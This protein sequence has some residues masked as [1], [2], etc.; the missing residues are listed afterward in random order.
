[1]LGSA[2]LVSAGLVSAV[3]GSAGLVSAVLGA[4]GWISWDSRVRSC[5]AGRSG[6][7]ISDQTPCAWFSVSPAM[8]INDI[9]GSRSRM[10]MLDTSFRI[11]VPKGTASAGGC[12]RRKLVLKQMELLRYVLSEIASKTQE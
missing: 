9:H 4:A 10:P 3:L 6:R 5:G 1:M 2:E 7:F 12:P 8:M 11:D